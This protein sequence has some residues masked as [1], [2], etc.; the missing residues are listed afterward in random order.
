M[1]KD[2]L[3]AALRLVDAIMDSDPRSE[4]FHERDCYPCDIAAEV[5]GSLGA[6]WDVNDAWWTTEPAIGDGWPVAMTRSQQA[7][8]IVAHVLHRRLLPGR[9]IT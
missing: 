8:K 4:P 2:E 5:V 1:T 9:K 7:E 6:H 3:T